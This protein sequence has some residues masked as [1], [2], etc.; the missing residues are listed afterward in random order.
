M[1]KR[2]DTAID[3]FC[4]TQ[5]FKIVARPDRDNPG[6]GGCDA[7][8]Q[9]NGQDFALEHT[10]INTFADHRLD[11]ARFLKVVASLEKNISAKCLGKLINISVPIG[12]VQPG[13]DWQSLS[14]ALETGCIEKISS[15]PP[16]ENHTIEL[17]NVPFPVTI[18][19]TDDSKRSAC[20]V[21]RR[22]AEVRPEDDMRRAIKE[23]TTQ[24][25]P[26]K[27]DGLPTILLID[28][29]DIALVNAHSLANAFLLA[30][31]QEDTAGL[32]QVFIA[33]TGS[34]PFHIY[35][36]KRG[37]NIYPQTPDPADFANLT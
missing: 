8:V 32:D 30:S 27:R 26:Y 4:E 15:L 18:L 19:H 2:E 11:D 29:D 25:A 21:A 13:I 1:S 35:P 20:Y 12:A 3:E 16:D 36:V 10:T 34:T 33:R 7:I 23:K 5:G 24:L 37:A 28:S 22:S 6:Q 31:N 9:R 17:S 14:Q